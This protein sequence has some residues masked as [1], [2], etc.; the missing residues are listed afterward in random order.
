MSYARKK[1]IVFLLWLLLVVFA[2]I[3]SQAGEEP[4]KWT[5]K[6][7]KSVKGIMV[8]KGEEW[9][10]VEIKDKVHKIPLDSLSEEDQEYVKKTEILKEFAV[11]LT[12]ASRKASDGDFD[13]RTLKIE[14]E[15]VNDR[16][17]YFVLVWLSQLRTTGGTS[18]ARE[19]EGFLTKDEVRD[20]EARFSNV[21]TLGGE[22]YRGFALRILDESGKVLKEGAEPSSGLKFLEDA[23]MRRKPKFRK[24]PESKDPEKEE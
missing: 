12:T 19:V 11:K 14:V 8:E 16:R 2:S 18:I 6:K 3:Q 1:S 10:K 7:G 22:A 23:R 15:G 13:V 24:D 21:R 9:V 5:N 20:Y 17:L 4:R